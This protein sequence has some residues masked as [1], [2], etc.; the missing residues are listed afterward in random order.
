MQDMESWRGEL[1]YGEK[2][3]RATLKNAATILM[4]HPLWAGRIGFCERRKAPVILTAVGKLW[5]PGLW[6]DV[7][8]VRF[9]GWA[10]DCLRGGDRP[11]QTGIVF[12]KRMI[13]MAVEDVAIRNRFDPVRSYLQSLEWDGIE[14]L[15]TFLVQYAGAADTPLTEEITR[16]WML[17][18]VA[19]VFQPGCQADHV[20]VLEGPQGG[21]KTTFFRVLGGDWAVEHY[22]DLATRDSI[23]ECNAAWIVELA[24][25][26]SIRRSKD[27]EAVKAFATRKFDQFVNKYDKFTT[28]WPRRF[29]L[30]ASLNP[31]GIGWI[32]DQTGGRRFWPVAVSQIS[33]AAIAECRDQLWAEAVHWYRQGERWWI[34]EGEMADEVRKVQAE[35]IDHDSWIETIEQY[36]TSIPYHTPDGRTTWGERSETLDHVTIPEV[37]EK[38]FN[39]PASRHDRASQMRVAKALKSIG[40]MLKKSVIVGGKKANWWLANGALERLGSE[41]SYSSDTK[42]DVP[43]LI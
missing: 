17:S 34:I 19:R 2:G 32:A 24:E 11:N 35:R 29:V 7:H 25:L 3:A 14:R 6:S 22:G 1:T 21:G 10:E 12:Q 5:E 30:G 40:Y 38:A 33:T 9:V 26:A 31:D 43:R 13:D 8:S 28:R 23:V 41:T 18:A 15:N 39:M 16:R 27:I 42:S 36:M 37:L 4:H 20:L